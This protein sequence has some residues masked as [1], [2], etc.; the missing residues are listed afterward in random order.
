MK[1]IS[2]Y[3]L[4]SYDFRFLLKSIESYY[5]IADEII[6]GVDNELLTWKK[7]KFFITEDFYNLLEKLDT[8]KKVKIFKENF[9]IYD[10]PM[11]NETFERNYLSTKCKNKFIIGVDCDEYFLNSEVLFNWIQEL[12]ENFE[13]DFTCLWKTV[14]KSI[15][16]D[17]LICCPNEQ[18][19]LGTCHKNSYIKARNTNFKKVQSPLEVLHFS[20]GR[21]EE[22][23]RQKLLNW[24]HANDFNTNKHLDIW[25]KVNLENYQEI[26]NFHPLGLKQWWQKLEKIRNPLL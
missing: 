1:K 21:T 24:G 9:H 6:L 7:N 2:F 13:E 11:Q 12:K 5:N 4:L 23:V 25:K 15:E 18:G 17:L 26:K 14:F 19:L 22:E 20:W 16:K 3:S 8:E 10:N